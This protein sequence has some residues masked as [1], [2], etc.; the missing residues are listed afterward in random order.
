ME[1]LD[2]ADGEEGADALDGLDAE[3]SEGVLGAEDWF[4]DIELLADA[5]REGADGTDGAEGAEGA[6]GADGTDGP[7]PAKAVPEKVML[8]NSKPLA[9]KIDLSICLLCMVNTSTVLMSSFSLL[10]RC[11]HSTPTKQRMLTRVCCAGRQKRR[12]K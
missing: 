7:E 2:T 1:G 11:I 4:D 10:T 9:T 5:G 6:E 3:R 12:P 8:L